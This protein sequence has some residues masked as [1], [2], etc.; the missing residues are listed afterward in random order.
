MN[1]EPRTTQQLYADCQTAIRAAL[2][3]VDRIHPEAATP[4]QVI[5]LIQSL[6][7][8]ASVALR[9]VALAAELTDQMRRLEAELNKYG[10]RHPGRI[11][12]N[13]TDED[14]GS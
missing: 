14:R 7:V 5:D 4:M 8:L 3:I 6:H 2:D 11:D 12:S 13:R 1:G 10:G 9:G